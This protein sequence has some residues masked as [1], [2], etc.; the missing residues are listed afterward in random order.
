MKKNREIKVLLL[1]ACFFILG[2]AFGQAT[3]VVAQPVDAN[4]ACRALNN[5][6]IDA[7]QIGLPTGGAVVQVAT[8][9]SAAAPGNVNGEFCRVLGVIR[10]VDVT[11]PNIRFQLNLPSNWN[12]KAVQMGGGGFNGVTV[13]GEGPFSNQPAAVPRPLAQGYVTYGSDSGHDST[14]PF[15][16]SFALNNEALANFARLQVKKTRDAAM[17]IVM[18]RYGLLPKRT[19]FVGGSQ[20]GKE[21]FDAAQSY[22]EDYDGIV[23]IYPAYNMTMMH[24]GSNAFAKALYANNGAGWINPAKV[25]LIFDSVM[26]ACDG[27]D[28]VVDGILSNP[29]GAACTAQ[30]SKF[31][32]KAAENPLRCAD[33]LDQ[34]DKCLSDAQIDAVKALNSRFDL[35]ITI[36]GG[37]TS[38]AKWP[39]LDGTNFLHQTLGSAP[40]YSIPPAATDAFQLRPSDATIRFLITRNLS[41]DSIKD[42][43]PRDWASR[44]VEISHLIDASTTDFD[45][46][47]AKGGKVILAHGTND[48][49]ITPYNTLD[50]YNRLVSRYT[51]AGLD[52]FLRFYMIPGFGHGV[53]LFNARLDSLAALDAWVERGIA[54]G[55]LLARDENTAAATAATNG[56]TRPVC[57]YPQ[58]PKY[59]GPASRTQAEVN[60]AAN[61]TCVLN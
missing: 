20:G 29:Q 40:K 10:P 43:N 32:L 42:F 47:R 16:G 51:Q 3:S 15:D 56:R 44:I 19:Y 46:F 28:G 54:P 24:M 6:K 5:F 26:A 7:S 36:K 59:T 14:V 61:Y 31:L 35:G 2:S 13:T 57:V 9:V 52:S 11:A 39:I 50:Y 49:S 17:T 55:E 12:N 33:G 21:A 60:S 58:W 25:K 30:T 1:I 8:L 38:Y 23:S 37:L 4:Q 34:G 18:K 45:A 41:L 53:G 22:P 48:S 27:L